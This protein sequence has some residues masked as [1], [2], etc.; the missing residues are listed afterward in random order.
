VGA[1]RYFLVKF[2]RGKS[3]ACDLDEALTEGPLPRVE[4]E[5]AVDAVRRVTAAP[6]EPG[7]HGVGFG[8]ETADVEHGPDGSGAPS[9]GWQAKPRQTEG[10]R[11]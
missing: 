10:D 5:D 11:G 4:L 1:V 7:A 2:T 8:A 9:L 3:I 6:G